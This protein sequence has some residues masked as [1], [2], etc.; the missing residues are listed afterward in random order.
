[1]A[2]GVFEGEGVG[3]GEVGG[4]LDV[5]FGGEGHYVFVCWS[6]FSF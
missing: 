2:V 3:V 6:H 5:E 1:M 4:Y